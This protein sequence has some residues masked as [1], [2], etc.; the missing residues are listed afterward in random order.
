[1]TAYTLAELRAQVR[2][3]GDYQN[4]QKFPDAD[5]NT[6]LQKAFKSFWQIVAD[7]HEGHWDTM[8]SVTASANI[9]F[10]ALPSDAWRIQAIDR[11]DGVDPIEL[12][13]V[14]VSDRNKWGISTGKPQAY[15]LVARGANLYPTPDATYT[16]NVHYTPLAPNLAESQPREWFN[17]WEEYL[18][19]WALM[20]LDERVG[21]P[22]TDRMNALAMMEAQVR[23]GAVERR[24]QEPE[25]LRLREFD[26]LNTFEEDIW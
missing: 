3:L 17:G 12:I 23:G 13:Q 22:L 2:F 10:V 16:L 14:G 5:V 4:V 1:M 9:G 7:S 15:R 11:L 26:T 8:A 21:R 6:L 25:Y 18:I 19:E 24:S 20:K